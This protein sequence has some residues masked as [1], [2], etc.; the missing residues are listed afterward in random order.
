MK[1]VLDTCALL[2]WTHEPERL[3]SRAAEVLRGLG[4]KTQGLIC[5]ASFWEIALKHG[6]GR[7]ELGMTPVEYHARIRRLPVQIEP[8]DAALWL[9]SVGLEW[10][11]RDPVDRL[12]VALARRQ[13][14]AVVTSDGKIQSFHP[15]VAW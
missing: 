12:V 4:G 7:L 9:D 8:V 11:H 10:D 2:Y 15:D 6:A 14:A 1:V 13:D 5:S 3:S